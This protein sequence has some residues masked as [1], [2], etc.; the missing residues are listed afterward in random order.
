MRHGFIYPVVACVIEAMRYLSLV[1]LFKAIAKRLARDEKEMPRNARIAIDVF[2][3]L[4][5]TFIAIIWANGLSHPLLTL[6]VAYL[7]AANAF[8]Y[9]YCHVWHPPYDA[10][11]EN[12]RS[13]FV[14]F[15]LSFCFSVLSFGYLYALP[16]ASGLQF[17]DVDASLGGIMFSVARSIFADIS[18]VT[19]VSVGAQILSLTESV[20]TFVFIS[21][22]LAS[23]IPQFNK[24]RE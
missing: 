5:W 19:P 23:S 16:F 11:E 24:P 1:E 13:R 8:T 3:I 6:A 21:I 14:S 2:N 20:V 7:I 12:M 9:F 17:S 4:K 22:I 15:V 18:S 10:S